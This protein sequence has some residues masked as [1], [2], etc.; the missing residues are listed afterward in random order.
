MI[1]FDS[2]GGV[3]EILVITLLCLII[4]NLIIFGL[5]LCIFFIIELVD[6]LKYSRRIG[7]HVDQYFENKKKIGNEP[8]QKTSDF[9]KEAVE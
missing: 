8:K 1:L 6:S 7:K 5:M 4:S 3:I 9:I 2:P